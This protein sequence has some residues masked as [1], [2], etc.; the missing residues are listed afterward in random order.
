VAACALL[1]V[2]VGAGIGGGWLARG[3]ERPAQSSAFGTEPGGRLQ[4]GSLVAEGRTVG[5]A[6]TVG[7]VTVYSGKKSWLYMTLDDGS[8]S[9]RAVCQVR[10][11]DGTTVPLGTFWLDKGYGAWGVTLPPGTGR[12][13]SAS[14]VSGKGVLA[15]AHFGAASTLF[16][17]P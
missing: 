3:S 10:L 16:V 11:A 4:T 15:T 9:G 14:V 8:W 2:A 13:E 7:E 12:I 5:E 6:R 17:W 1:L